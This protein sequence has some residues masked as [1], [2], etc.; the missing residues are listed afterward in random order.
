MKRPPRNTNLMA[1]TIALALLAG[2]AFA[3]QEPAAHDQVTITGKPIEDAIRSFVGEVA[4][5]VSPEKQLARWDRSICAGLVA[6]AF[7]SADWCLVISVLYALYFAL[8]PSL[9]R[10]RR[11]LLKTRAGMS[12]PQTGRDS[13]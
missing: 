10:R 8:T 9:W 13:P 11:F 1:A 6:I 5:G 12:K 3:Q 4:K 7:F 2:P